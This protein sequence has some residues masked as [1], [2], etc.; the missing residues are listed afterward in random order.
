MYLNTKQL[1]KNSL[2]FLLFLCS[3]TA[4]F[5]QIKKDT[6]ALSEITLK[7]S[8]IKN[9]LQNAAS[10]VSVITAADI[11][12]SDGIIL[13]PVLNKIPGVTMQQG[14]LNTNRITIRGIGARSQYGTNK[15]KAYFDGIPLSSGEGETTIDDID[16][17]SVEKLEIIK[18]PNSTSFGSGLGGVIQ[19]FSKETPL[20]E[21]FGKSTVTF[22]SFGLL[23]QRLSAGYS[24]AKINLFASYT[25][26]ET[27]GF[28]ANSSYKRKTF[29]LHGKQQISSKGNLSFL[30]IFTRLKAFIPSS[31]NDNDL[32]NNPE[33]A[34][35]TWAAAQGF[36][37]YDKL[38]LGLKY[39][40]QFSEKW[41]LQTTVFSNFKDAYEPRPFDIL[42]DKTSAVGFRSHVNYKDKIFSLP[43]EMSFGTELL[44]E[45]YEYSLF[46][47]LYQS[48]PGQGSIQGDEFS[49]I[50]QNRQYGNYYLQ[51]EIWISEKL[52]LE[53]GMAF[54][55]TKYS[56]ED[57]FKNSAGGQKVP[58]TFGNIWSPRV[59]LSYKVSN[60]KNIFMLVSKGFSVPSVAETLTPEGQINTD[61]KP[62][63]GW[64]Y[65]LGFKGNWLTNKLYTEVTFYT[66]QI[67]NLLVARRTANDQFVGINAGSS[68]HTGLELLVNYKL[69]ELTSLQITPYFSAAVN[70]FKFKEF[71]DGDADYSGN[72]LTGVPEKQFNF[73]VDLNIKN[74]FSVNTSFRTMGKIP[75]NDSNTKYSER[76]S[77]LDIKTTYVFSILKILKTELNAGINNALDTKYAANILPNAIGF[78]TAAP[79]YF[80]PGNPVNL[81]GGFSVAYLF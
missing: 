3:A 77:L 33:K 76:Y 32:R 75:L 65:E 34:A 4:F 15:I 68:S 57:V 41:L 6:I 46:K 22:G 58:F 61:L 20:L 19:L 37:S 14:A 18:G 53:T 71:L 52:H 56:L 64:N 16:L 80:Y 43:F 48:Q 62:E 23:Q 17:A 44:I 51:M 45:I 55:V 40:H 66:A 78:G 27:N 42:D 35:A 5:G 67:K 8:P 54:N 28:R 7:G 49:A 29:N 30:G 50:K 38:L 21:S 72:Q 2:S 63:I 26:L 60:G 31:I 13:T 74:G 59:G 81:Y 47:N 10:S 1:F 25:D 9:V 79:R 73:G 69:L 39:D 12:K 24:D 70:D 11:N 36:E